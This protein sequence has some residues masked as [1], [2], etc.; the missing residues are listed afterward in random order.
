MTSAIGAGPGMVRRVPVPPAARE[1]S[2]LARIDYADAFLLQADGE[3][4]AEQWSR[5]ILEDAPLPM[6]CRLRAGWAALGLKLHEAPRRRS[7]LGWEIRHSTPEV[8]VLGAGSRIGMP[9]E[10]LFQRQP[11]RLL[12]ATFVQ[13]DN[14]TARAVWARV[15]ADHVRLVRDLLDRA[16]R[17]WRP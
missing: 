2:T 4:T 7:V 3:R 1:L 16:A 6:R 17:R 9:G 10:L 13:H 15:E 12:F 14:D 8:V 5:A 11:R